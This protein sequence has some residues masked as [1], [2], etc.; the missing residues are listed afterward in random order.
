MWTDKHYPVRTFE[1]LCLCLIPEAALRFPGKLS[2]NPPQTVTSVAGVNKYH[3]CEKCGIN[4][5]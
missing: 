2:P 5:V 1:Q 4:I 3:T